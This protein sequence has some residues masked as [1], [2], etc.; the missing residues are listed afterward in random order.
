MLVIVLAVGLVPGRAVRHHPRGQ[1]ARSASCRRSGPSGRSTGSRCSPRPSRAWCAT[2]RSREIAVEEVVLDDLVELRTGDQVPAD[3][4][5]RAAG[6]PRD[7]RV[8]AHRRGRRRSTRR[9]ATR[10]S[11]AAS[12]SPGSGRF[13]ATRVGA[14]AYARKLA[15]EARRFTLTRS[16]LMDGINTAAALHPVRAVPGRGACC[17]GASSANDEHR[18]T[19]C[20][21]DW[22]PAVVGMVPEGLVLLTSLAFGI[23]AVTLAR[24]KVLVQELPAVEG[25]ARVD[26]V[27][28]DKTGTLTEGDVA[29]DRLELLDGADDA[30]VGAALSA[31]SPTTRTAT[32]RSPRS[33]RRSAAPDGWTRTGAVP[34]SSARK[35]SARARSPARARG[36]SG[37]PEMVLPR[38]RRRP[39]R[40]RADELAAEGRRVLLLAHTRRGARRRGAPGRARAGGAR[41]ARGADPP[42]RGRDAAL[43]RRAGRGAEGDLRRQPAHR[44]RGRRAGSG[45]PAPTSRYDARELP[46]DPAELAEVLEHTTGVRPGHPAAEAGDGRRAA[47]EGPRRGDDR[48]R[49]ERRARAEGRRH[50][51]RHGLGRRG[52]PCGRAARAARRQVRDAAR[53][54]W[55]RA[56]G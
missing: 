2:A 45:C 24:R 33:A 16:E 43:L 29:F 8:A 26:V 49:R 21:V 42:R 44:R 37:R 35:W 19:R 6:G 34:F 50:R 30:A 12:W 51:R 5:V 40:A 41:A 3:G 15:T 48:R 7:R 17:S 39:A 20:V 23:A 38:R 54:S 27:C 11:R 22:S 14:E 31:P 56:G 46:D 55:P 13:Q 9:R 36:S 47:V 32:P 53:A 4:I 1:L 25:L 18:R 28:L 10:C 52:H